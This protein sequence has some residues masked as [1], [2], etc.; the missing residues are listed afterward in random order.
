[1]KF[2]A[3]VA[4]WMTSIVAFDSVFNILCF[5]ID[6]IKRKSCF[7]S[8]EKTQDVLTIGFILS[9]KGFYTV[10]NKYFFQDAWL[11]N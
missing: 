6:K 5:D 7:Y 4:F 1:M 2:Y 3:V 9:I 11:R 10:N 8:Q